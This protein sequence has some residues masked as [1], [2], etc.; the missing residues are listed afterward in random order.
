MTRI[1]HQHRRPRLSATA[2]T[3]QSLSAARKSPQTDDLISLLTV[4]F[5][6]KVYAS[7]FRSERPVKSVKEK[8]LSDVDV[9]RCRCL[10]P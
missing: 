5:Y 1:N 2:R 3:C 6:N 10:R 7:R 8:L 4:M 9:D